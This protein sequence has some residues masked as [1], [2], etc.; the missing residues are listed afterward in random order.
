MQSLM[1]MR[2]AKTNSLYSHLSFT[3]LRSLFI[4]TE[5]STA[6]LAVS[7]RIVNP[8]HISQTQHMHEHGTDSEHAFIASGWPLERVNRHSVTM[9]KNRA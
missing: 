6:F 8:T 9:K 4:T 7:C 5:L 1:S 2:H 3:L